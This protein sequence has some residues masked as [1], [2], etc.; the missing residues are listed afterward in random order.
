MQFLLGT[1]SAPAT[2]D[3]IVMANLGYFQLK[4]RDNTDPKTGKSRV[5]LEKKWNRL[6]YCAVKRRLRS[7]CTYVFQTT[8]QRENNNIYR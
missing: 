1:P 6:V 5:I 4:V 3:T 7:R 8:R 2:Y